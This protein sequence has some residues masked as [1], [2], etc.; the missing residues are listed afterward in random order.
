M[1]NQN[2]ETLRSGLVDGVLL[3]DADNDPHMPSDFPLSAATLVRVFL[4]PK[5]ALSRALQK[6]LTGLPLCATISAPQGGKNA[7]DFVMAMHAGILHASLPMHL[8]FSI[9]TNDKALSA[10]VQELQRV[11]RVAT[12]WTSHPEAG[13]EETPRAQSSRSPRPRRGGR[14]GSRGSGRRERRPAGTG[15]TSDTAGAGRR[16][17]P[18]TAPESAAPLAQDLTPAPPAPPPAPAQPVRPI[19]EVTAAYARMLAR[20]K[21]PP[22]RLKALLNDIGNRTANSGWQP[23]EVLEELKLSHGLRIDERGRVSRA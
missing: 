20:A 16:A 11:G 18:V 22:N 3:I 14:G 9:V 4:R 23:V 13:A 6:R 10:I 15:G 7:A 21:N 5:A 8:P 12:L 1:E 2:K 17:K 19:A